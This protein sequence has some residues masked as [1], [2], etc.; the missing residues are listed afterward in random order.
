[1][2][3]KAGILHKYYQDEEQGLPLH[4]APTA[5]YDVGGRGPRVQSGLPA[6]HSLNVFLRL[7]HTLEA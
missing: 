3:L 4:E 2:K 1:M 5:A 6:A 7:L